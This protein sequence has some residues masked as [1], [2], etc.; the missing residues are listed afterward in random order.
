MEIE[1]EGR[2]RRRSVSQVLYETR[3]HAS[4]PYSSNYPPVHHQPN[5]GSRGSLLR[6]LSTQGLSEFR[7]KWTTNR[8]PQKLSKWISMF[9]SP[10]GEYV[11]IAVGNEIT[12][13][14]RDD[15]YQDPCG[16]FTSSY[17]VTFMLGAWSEDHGVLGVFDNTDTLYFIRANGEEITRVTK[18]H[19]KVPLP[20]ISFVIHDDKD[21]TKSCLCTFSILASDG[22]AHDIEISQDPSASISTMSSS[23]VGSLLQKQFPQNVF[24]C[25]Y[26]PD[27][28]LLA[29]VSSTV[30]IA[31]T[32]SVSIGPYSISLWQWCRQSGLLQVASAEFEGLYAKTKGYAD[33]IS[34][35]KVIF[36]P[37]GEFVATLDLRGCLV[38]YKLDK[39]HM[40]SVVYFKQK[41]DLSNIVDFTWW[42]DHILVIASRSGNISM[43]DI[44]SGVKVL[45]NDSLYSLPILERV[46]K[47]PGC[48]FILE[49][50]SSENTLQQSDL[51][52]FEPVTM[53]KYKQ[54]DSAKLQWSLMS[55]S[56]RS[57]EELYDILISSHQFQAA[58]ELANR[59]RLNKD[60]V[61]KAQWLHSS[62]GVNE[63]N[64]LLSLIED[65]DFV[66]SECL[67]RV[68]PTEDAVRALLT[69]GL[70]LTNHYVFSKVEDEEGSPSWDF[71][72]ARLKL[73]QFRDRLETFL[74]I[75]M[76]RFSAQDYSKFRSL[77]INEAATA[78]AESGKIGALN[79]LFKRHP[80]SISPCMLEVLAAIPETV[81][82][83]TY[84]QLLPG[85]SP[86][87][88]TALREEDWVECERMV[89]FIKTLPDNHESRIQIRTEPIVKRL[90]GFT[91]PST[92]ELSI[93]YK[94]RAR[95]MDTLSGQ[96]DNCLS[97]VDFA[98][99]KGIKEL[100]QFHELISY[101]HQL[102]YSAEDDH[103]MNFSMSLTTWEQLSDYEKFKLML[104][105]FNEENVIKRLRDRAVPFMQ[106]NFGIVALP[107]RD[108]VADEPVDSFLVQWMKEVAKENKIEVC[109]VVVEEGCKEFGGSNF[110]RNE[111][112]AVDGALQCLYL[113]TAT[114]KWSAMASILS[115]LPYLH[116]SDVE[117]LK[118]RLKLAEG[119][120]EAGRLLMVYQ[121]PKPIAF[122]LEA[123]SDSKSVKQI[124]RLILS[125]FI[126]RQPGR[127]DN[128]WANMWRDFQSLQEKA[129]PF[130]DLEYMLM[131]FCRGLLKA[132]KFS[133]ARNYLK[134]S[135]SLVLPTE[136]AENIIILAAREYFFSASSLSCSEIWKAK[137]CLN[138]L[139]SSRNVM[140]E[141]DMIDALT[142]KLPRLGVNILP[143]QFRQIKDPME[144]IKLAITS[145]SGAYLNV[146]ELIEIAKLLGLNS[147]DEISAVQEA[148]AREAAVA[149]DLRLAF[150]LCLVMAKK[151]HGPVWD[152]CAALARGPAL[153][154]VDISSRKQLLGFA[155]SHCDKDSIGELLHAW[156][157][158]DMLSQ[159]EKLAMLTGK[160]VPELKHSMVDLID[161]SGQI[162]A[163]L[164][165]EQNAHF[166]TIKKTLS[167]VAN[168]LSAE[169]DSDYD[170]LLRENGK[171]LAFVALR[172]PWLLE[173]SEAAE[174]GKKFV[175]G[176]VSG[177][178]HMSI[179]TQSMAII[180]SWLARNNF[181][182][183]DNLIASLVKSILEPPVTEE[184]DIL[185]CS[186]LLNLN[187][188]FYG[189]QIIEEQVKSRQDYNEICSM[190]NLGMIYSLLHNSGAECEGP[191]QRR[192]LLLRKFQQKY[193]SLSSDERNKIDQ[194]QSSF[195]REW[196]VKL[197]EQKRVADHTRAI[198]QIIP[199]IETAR[200]LSGDIDYM[201]SVIFSFIESVKS[202]KKRIL[203][204]VLNL[205]SNY[206]IDQTKV[207]LKFLCST[208]LS[209]IWTVD[210]IKSEVSEFES[211]ILD[212]AEDVFK[213]LSLSV[214][215]EIDGR[216]K[217]RLAYIYELLSACFA[218]V[219]EKKPLLAIVGSNLEHLSIEELDSFY[220]S[221]EQECTK[222]SFIKDLNFKNI[223]GLSGL[224][225]ER[226]TNEVYAH[227]NEKNVEP[228]AEMMKT[229]TGIFKDTVPEGLVP[230][231]YVYGYYV[232][233]SLT[234]LESNGKSEV[235]FQ[236][237]ESL[238]SFI[239]EMELTYDRCKKYIRL[240]AYPG[241][242]V[243]G[244]MKK[245]FKITPCLNDS[246][247]SL[248]L[249]S[250]WTDDLIM[251]L[252]F[253]LRLID[254]LQKFVSSNDLEGKFSPAC[255]MICLQ[256][257]V[258]LVKDEKISTSEGWASIFAYINFGLVGD[259]YTEILNF[260]R[261]MVFSGCRFKAIAYVYREAISHFSPDTTLSGEIR[262]HY[263]YIMDLP[264][265]YIRILETILRDLASG[266]LDH[267][268]L[269]CVLSS[270]SE[271]DGDLEDLKTVRSTV[272]DRLVRFSDDM[273]ISS[274]V[275]VHMLELMQ[276]ITGL[277]TNS[278]SF[279]TK[280]Q[281]NVVPWE[282][283]G[284]MGNVSTSSDRE[285]PR[286]ADG[287]NRFTHTLI[288]LKSSQLLST[289]SPN[290]EITPNDLS[291]VDSA[292]SCFL[293]LSDNAVSRSHIDALIAVL[294]EWERVFATTSAV[295]E[296][297]DAEQAP[298]TPGSDWGNDDWDEGWE[299]FQ[300]EETIKKETTNVDNTPSVHALHECWEE[301]FKKLASLSEFKDMLKIIDQSGQKGNGILLNED[302]ARNLTQ[303]LLEVDCFL[304]LKIALLLPYAN[305]R[306]DRLAAVEEKLKQGN[307]PSSVLNDHE[308]FASLLSS[309]LIS[310]IITKPSFG[311]TF[312]YLNY[313]VGSFS[314]DCQEAQFSRL[315]NGNGD[316]KNDNWSVFKT[317]I[318]PCYLSEL[319]KANQVVLAGLVVTK[320]MHTTASL[321]LINVAEASLRKYLEKQLDI[322]QA[323]ELKLEEMKFCESIVNTV[324]RLS[325]RSES[326]IKSAL[327]LLSP[328][329][330]KR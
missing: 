93:W 246:F 294:G 138:I 196:N 193:T 171:I 4:R 214:Y 285:A 226:V 89:N 273:E 61:L 219:E 26:H 11:A 3:H 163:N 216:N 31:S 15:N 271:L 97:L 126:R 164:N 110:F 292:V 272:W 269:Y 137:E 180:L 220:K 210:D 278:T 38:I 150:D 13:L 255:V 325:S 142:V 260:C 153:E 59:H 314:R 201:E 245:F 121:V 262:Q 27:S 295:E 266:S 212:C 157:D 47:L 135:G 122:F 125:K 188:A 117:G 293:K 309:G 173:L 291:T 114:D 90:M 76:G 109:L 103:D 7:E 174:Y 111:A 63:I 234:A 143:M 86:P 25:G 249:D 68:P 139:P 66:L 1:E 253:W 20:I 170:S 41:E 43:I 326:L 205:A 96:L 162:I 60:E 70:R 239:N 81:S 204:D 185:G 296:M 284:N 128:D 184:E 83:Q 263:E 277:G 136:K 276:F 179:G 154:N 258:E 243:M 261:S 286:V 168:F 289:I 130:V 22:S 321:G 221:M 116:G 182:P 167:D 113:F 229:L 223:A 283:W 265:L 230:W 202:E 133:L 307:I 104:K 141:A 9:I 250:K 241:A 244:I 42:T 189:V 302:A 238:R 85:R 211:K 281:A 75:N 228:L 308:L 208:L 267:Q 215:P 327:G 310:T 147:H 178:P 18:Q 34:S 149:G 264:H 169:K 303:S 112:E 5:E 52:L 2:R 54:F 166:S 251:L 40:L 183:R 98:C 33:H 176:S 29:V 213:T 328:T 203:K 268:Y 56:K 161:S 207:L 50:R 235:H 280:L 80:Y 105:G 127:T 274:H 151:G 159:C 10:S 62:Q 106:K 30:S 224:N 69:Y 115:K 77:P 35:P 78:L 290:L 6:F 319:V 36:S 282:G 134:G 313:M 330:V 270:L 247:D 194:A 305:I 248:S 324:A 39:K 279:S 252:N 301:I 306:L 288:A 254:D 55:F 119:H 44:N 323:D 158:L 148:I 259:V 107:H 195:W 299:N 37:Q 192:E 304:A 145:Q 155:L 84:G 311:N 200:F 191:A 316:D 64:M 101:L 48:I 129:F 240:I 88:V 58:L 92:D 181:S 82:I 51:L 46:P 123:Q 57:V 236:S 233:S 231:P 67:D 140:I 315:K 118:K 99:R 152:L 222:L 45:E 23:N 257:F 209:E 131:E 14:Q 186:F 24:C 187:D 298:N 73:L 120:V 256:A 237:P 322:L 160:D 144:I 297:K 94:H 32:S 87:Q 72:L 312:S 227:V 28:S 218:R 232:S 275:R 12:I 124:L 317:V 21:M 19:L 329:D 53:E 197:E 175:P 156:K 172:L 17:P 318:L 71:R 206:G 132:G 102:I 198:E 177:R 287:S 108:E 74:G 8:H 49:S 79:L 65:Q 165:A 320:I 100:Q 242:S 95:D 91:W 199:G 146:D 16:I 300:E 217:E 190:M 225:L